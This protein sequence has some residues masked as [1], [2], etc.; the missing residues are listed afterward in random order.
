MTRR[1]NVA[2][3]N[4]DKF[5]CPQNDGA[6]YTLNRPPNLT[7]S[8]MMEEKLILSVDKTQKNPMHSLKSWP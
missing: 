7:V 8:C 5:S 6:L 4:E 3:G 2:N 1:C